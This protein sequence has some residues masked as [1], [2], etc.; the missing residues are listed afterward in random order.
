MAKVASLEKTMNSIQSEISSLK[1]RADSAEI[2]LKEMDKS[3]QFL[4]AEV[5][6]LK[7]QS[8]DNQQNIKALNER[9]LCQEVYNRRENLRFFGFP[10]SL[11]STTEDSGEVLYRFLDRDL[12]GAR[13][14]EFRR[15]E[16]RHFASYHCTVS[17]IP[18]S[19]TGL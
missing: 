15:V 8:K 19:G 6:D 13:N 17:Y 14:I 2:N 9:T 16:K 5:E 12:E 3:L 1:T 7:A 18:R 11:E 10:E 4:N